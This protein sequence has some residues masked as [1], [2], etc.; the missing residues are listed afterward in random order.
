[1][2]ADRRKS[3]TAACRSILPPGPTNSPI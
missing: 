2:T 3:W 1:V